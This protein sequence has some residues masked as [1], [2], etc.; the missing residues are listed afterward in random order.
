MGKWNYWTERSYYH[1]ELRDRAKGIKSEMEA[2]KQI[3]Q[4]ISDKA[5]SYSSI[6]DAG[7]G[8]GHFILSLEKKLRDNFKYLGVDITE[9]HIIDAIDIFKENSNYQF[10]LGDIRNLKVEDKSFEVS[11]C[12]NTIPHIPNISKAINELI[13]V[14]KND[15]FIRMLIGD[16]VLITKKALSNVFDENGEPESFMYVNI[17]DENYLKNI[18]GDKG[19]LLIYEDVFDP[20]AIMRHF[21][22][23]KKTAGKNIATRIVEGTQFK[24]YLM[25]PW[26]IIHIKLS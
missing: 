21:E 3:S 23:H 11:I 2:A 6:L 14:T 12:S 24:G 17:Y 15:I 1:K 4:L 10:Q 19:E 5:K 18:I 22:D 25:L 26:K 13:R 16:E 7:C 9:Q 8:T 20:N